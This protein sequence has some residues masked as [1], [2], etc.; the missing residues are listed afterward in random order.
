[1]D[2]GPWDGTISV[3][4]GMIGGSVGVD[5]GRIHVDVGGQY[6]SG[7]HWGGAITITPKPRPS[8]RVR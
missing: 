7:G 5:I 3:S 6:R 2:L 8:G 4:G 1:M